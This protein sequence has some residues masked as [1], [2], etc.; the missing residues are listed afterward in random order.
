MRSRL[1]LGVALAL[2]ACAGALAGGLSREAES[3]RASAPSPCATLPLG[4][5]SYTHVVWIWMENHSYGEVIGAPEAPYVNGLASACG[6]A[7]NYHN[8]SHPSLPNYIAATSGLPLGALGRLTRDCSP[9]RRCST[10]ASSIF[11]QLSTW[12][13]YEESMPKSC[14]RRNKRTYAV[15][16]NPPPYYTTL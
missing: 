2:A 4:S 8:I 3:A 12:R 11:A 15:R 5:T 14:D 1:V 13:A 6:L 7:T 16:H 9:S 10:A